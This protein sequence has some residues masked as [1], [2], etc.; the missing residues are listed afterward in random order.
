MTRATISNRA[1][2]DL[3]D[4]VNYSVV[5][6]GENQAFSYRE[7]LGAV[8]DR[9]GDFPE[10]GRRQPKLGQNIHRLVH[11]SHVLIYQRVSDNEVVVLR[12]VHGNR[13]LTRRLLAE[14]D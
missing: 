12:V 1:L 13:R 11:E 14:P 2:A 7:E 10:R 6:W 5:T 4:I 8:I 9:L 3:K